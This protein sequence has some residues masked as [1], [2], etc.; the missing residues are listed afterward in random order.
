[1]SEKDF[2]TLSARINGFEFA[3]AVKWLRE[4]GVRPTTK[5]QVVALVVHYFCEA[6]APGVDVNEVAAILGE[7]S[8]KVP[9]RIEE[10]FKSTVE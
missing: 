6:N 9:P 10:I 8:L 2:I 5:S 3:R 1:M 4:N 7:F